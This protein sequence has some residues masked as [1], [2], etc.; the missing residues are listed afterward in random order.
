MKEGG[1]YYIDATKT[2]LSYEK[3]VTSSV[4]SQLNNKQK[5]ITS[6]VA[7]PSGGIDGD[8]YLQYS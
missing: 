6:G 5:T 2:E 7:T 3:G 4:Q 1:G 8:I